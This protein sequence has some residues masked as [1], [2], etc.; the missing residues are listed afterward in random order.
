MPE[1]TLLAFA[2]H[3]QVLC[4]LPA[5]GG[6]AEQVLAQFARAGIDFD[7]LAADLQRERTQ[8]FAKSWNELLE[9]IVPKGHSLGKMVQTG[10]R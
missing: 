8:A 10:E 7:A 6:D 9:C 5:D 2:E 4:V 3:G 1:A